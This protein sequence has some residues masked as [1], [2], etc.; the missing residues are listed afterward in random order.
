MNDVRQWIYGAII[1]LLAC[2]GL[3]LSIVYVSACG[4]TVTCV[5]AAPLVIR[6]PIPTLIPAAQAEENASEQTPDVAGCQVAAQ[7]LVG[8][9]VT[10]GSPESEPFSFQ[11]VNGESCQGTFAD[12]VQHLF[13]DNSTW[14][15]GQLGCTSCHNANLTD[16]S[17]GLDLSSHKGILA[18]SRRSYEG[19]KGADILG[20]GDW[21]S[22]LL[23]T[24]LV[25][26]GLGPNGHAPDGQPVQ[27]VLVYAGQHVE[28]SA[29]TPTATP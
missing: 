18:G 26:Q 19:A 16:R 17:A 8:A 13:V 15:A 12:D 29:V 3:M 2:I 23:H 14:Y 5:Q 27:L 20:G 11:D 9:W 1:G 21:E 25:E 10:A 24:V 7:D 6:T 28:E 4:F 22:S